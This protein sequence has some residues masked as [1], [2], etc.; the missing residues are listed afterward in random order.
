MPLP[1][2]LILPGLLEDVDAFEPVVAGTQ[3]M[4]TAFAADMTRADSIAGL[5]AEALKQAPEGPF[6]LAGHSMG[7][8]VALE[9]LRQAPER[10]TT[11]AL[12]N[13]NARADSKEST[14]NRRRL[15]ALADRDFEGVINT[16]MTKVLS[17]GHQKDPVMTGT[18]AAMAHGVG[19]DAFKRQQEAIINRIDSRA[20]L[21]AIRCPTL[22]VAARDD[23]IMPLEWLEEL[24]K[25]IPGARL[26][27]V[28]DSGHMASI[29]QPEAVV[30]I[31]R[32]WIQGGSP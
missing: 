26:E 8:Y 29:E 31:L 19:K 7:G 15:M 9:I 5:A 20:H 4:A 18:V 1:T 16:L 12:L 25:G 28:E 30:R 6:M 10:V 2:L 21:A 3:D 24:A 32:D 22:V 27:I 17:P 11:L 14:G 13:T 23:A